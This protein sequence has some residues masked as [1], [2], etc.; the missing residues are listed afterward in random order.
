MTASIY[1]NLG[2]DQIELVGETAAYLRSQDVEVDESAL[3]ELV[4][5]YPLIGDRNTIAYRYLTEVDGSVT[6]EEARE[7]AWF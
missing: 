6:E 5:K 4:E 1:E 2:F 3:A 7:I